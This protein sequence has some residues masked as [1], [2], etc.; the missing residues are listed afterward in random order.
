MPQ[1]Y[2]HLHTKNEKIE[3]QKRTHRQLRVELRL[4]PGFC[5]PGILV[6]RHLLPIGAYRDKA[7]GHPVEPESF[8]KSM[9]EGLK[10]F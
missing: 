2:I 5:L 10:F 7:L 1:R 4:E 8:C 6:P 3:V 9:T